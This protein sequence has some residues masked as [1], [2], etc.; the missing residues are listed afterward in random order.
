MIRSLPAILVACALAVARPAEAPAADVLDRA[1][2]IADQ[3]LSTARRAMAGHP[4]P[5]PG[6]SRRWLLPVAARIR[7]SPDEAVWFLEPTHGYSLRVGAWVA[8]EPFGL[9]GADR[10]TERMRAEPRGV[11]SYRALRIDLQGLVRRDVAWKHWDLGQDRWIIRYERERELS[12]LAD[13]PWSG[14]WLG[15][16]SLRSDG[17]DTPAGATGGPLS[18]LILADGTRCAVHLSSASWTFTAVG[19]VE[20]NRLTAS[21]AAAASPGANLAVE[22]SLD[23][24]N[25]ALRG[26]MR[27]ETGAGDVRRGT[28]YLRPWAGD[29]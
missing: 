20:S 11:G 28:F 19:V 24:D 1:D 27:I 9:T 17:A 6:A 15:A 2:Q 22:G 13:D 21:S 3:V 29:G 4:P 26:G 5:A 23:R 12:G 18:A 25:R 14:K 10:V 8:Q 7:L 16:Y